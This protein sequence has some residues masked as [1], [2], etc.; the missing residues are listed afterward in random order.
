MNAP[1]HLRLV[2]KEPPR[3]SMD[4]EMFCFIEVVDTKQ[5]HH[6]LYIGHNGEVKLVGHAG[7][8][9]AAIEWW[10]H[11]VE[12]RIDRDAPML[13]WPLKPAGFASS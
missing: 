5:H 11:R 2:P 1:P 13:H 8:E 6:E 12:Q 4:A 10:M 7:V 3:V 9:I